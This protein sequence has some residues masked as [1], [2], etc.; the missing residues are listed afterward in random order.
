M[1]KQ[2]LLILLLFAI[3]TNLSAQKVGISLCSSYSVTDDWGAGT[4][5]HYY[6]G[7]DF[8]LGLEALYFP[9]NAKHPEESLVEFSFNAHYALRFHEHFACVPV[10]GVNCSNAMHQQPDQGIKNHVFAGFNFGCGALFPINSHWAIYSEYM[11]TFGNHSSDIVSVGL[12]YEIHTKHKHPHEQLH[13]FSAASP[14][15]TH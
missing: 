11:H 6:F 14:T 12:E 2:H 7:N 13:D 9:A 10:L 15:H 4:N 5:F 8:S 3:S 1:K